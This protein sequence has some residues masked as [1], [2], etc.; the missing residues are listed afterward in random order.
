MSEETPCGTG[1]H[2]GRHGEISYTEEITH[3]RGEPSHGQGPA[4]EA[5]N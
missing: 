5:E 2:T 3:R 4:G 1:V